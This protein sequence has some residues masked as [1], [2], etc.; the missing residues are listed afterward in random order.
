M[1]GGIQFRVCLY[2]AL[3]PD[4]RLSANDIAEQFGVSTP[5]DVRPRINDALRADFIVNAAEKRGRGHRALYAAGPR[6]LR[7]R[8]AAGAR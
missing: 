5:R 8:A 6:L 4:A 3:N 2:L 7:L 1:I